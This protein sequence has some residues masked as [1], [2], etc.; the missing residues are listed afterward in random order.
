V[1]NFTNAHGGSALLARPRTSAS[2]CTPAAKRIDG[3]PPM[4]AFGA[5]NVSAYVADQESH[6]PR[7]RSAG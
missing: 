6:P 7:E 1:A 3:V 2:T 4:S 5:V